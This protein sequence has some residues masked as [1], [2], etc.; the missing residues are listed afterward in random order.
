VRSQEPGET[1]VGLAAIA[2]TNTM[3]TATL[4]SFANVVFVH[5]SSFLS[6]VLHCHRGSGVGRGF[7]DLPLLLYELTS[8]Q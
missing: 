8:S 7:R 3:G 5:V 6:L 1:E 4:I 2:V